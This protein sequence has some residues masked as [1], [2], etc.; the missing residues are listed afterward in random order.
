MVGKSPSL[1]WVPDLLCLNAELSRSFPAPSLSWVS[2]DAQI[3][4]SKTC[5]QLPVLVDTSGWPALDFQTCSTAV[6]NFSQSFS[7]RLLWIINR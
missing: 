2:A 1:S 5:H 7:P 3:E 6:R 4:R